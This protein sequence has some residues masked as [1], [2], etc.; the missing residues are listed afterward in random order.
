VLQ[1]LAILVGLGSLVCWIFVLIKIFQD[2]NVGLGI[3]GIICPLFA[4][5]YGWMKANEYGIQKV[6]LIW[7]VLIVAGIAVNVAMPRP[8]LP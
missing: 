7:T 2:G 4:F 5:I 1:I 3:V 8:Q 6:M